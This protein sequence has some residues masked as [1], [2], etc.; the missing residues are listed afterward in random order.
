MPPYRNA[1]NV[2]KCLVTPTKV[3]TEGNPKCLSILRIFGWA[4]E[5]AQ[6]LRTLAVLGEDLVPVPSTHVSAKGSSSGTVLICIDT[7]TH[8]I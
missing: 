6:Q 5:M 1:R 4:G 3:Q 8:I 2:F 7:N